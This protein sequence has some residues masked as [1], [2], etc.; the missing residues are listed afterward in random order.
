MLGISTDEE[1]MIAACGMHCAYCSVHQKKKKPCPGCR[2]TDDGKPEH[3]RNCTI[4]NC[5]HAKNLV[6]CADCP[7]SPCILIKR[8]DT[9]YRT[10]YN[11]SLIH[12]MKVITEKGMREY[13]EQEKNRFTCPACAGVLN[14]HDKKCADCGQVFEVRPLE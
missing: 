3:C 8:L 11:E 13:L 4:K 2:F 9:S 6:F 1:K 5:S 10:R 7:D 12:T 14:M